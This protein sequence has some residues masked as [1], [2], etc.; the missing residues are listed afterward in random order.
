MKPLAYAV[1]AGLIA[2]VPWSQR[3]VERR[4]GEYRPH[5]EVLYLW[6]GE[7]VRRL[8]PGFEDLMADVYWLRTVQYFGGKRAAESKRFELLDPLIDITVTLDE[9]FEMA[10]LYGAIFLSQ[11]P[12]QGAGQPR[13][14]VD[15]LERGVRRTGSYVLQHIQAHLVFLYLDDAPRAADILMD[16][17]RT[18]KGS[19]PFQALAADMLQKRGERDVARRIWKDMYNT[20]PGQIRDNARFN[21]ERLDLL[22]AV[23]AAQARV[24]EAA[25]RLGRPPRSLDEALGARVPVDRYGIPLGYDPETGTV[26]I[27]RRSSYWRPDRSDPLTDR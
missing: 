20:Y 15:L 19:M 23:D 22:D 11:P 12:P 18:H 9:R 3:R 10:Y 1:L 16:I 6:S 7:Y 5:E 21:L 24:N 13:K 14:A 26:S 8:C 4:F 27:S 17:V 2:L 25:K